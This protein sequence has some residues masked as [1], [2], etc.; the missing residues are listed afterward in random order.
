[1]LGWL[2]V[3]LV[4]V[5]LWAVYTALVYS[6]LALAP[7]P[8]PCLGFGNYYELRNAG[9][10]HSH[11]LFS[12]LHKQWGDIYTFWNLGK[13]TPLVCVCSPTIAKEVMMDKKNFSSR[14][15]IGWES[16]LPNS[17]LILPT[18][19]TWSFHRRLVSPC[20]ADKYFNCFA[21]PLVALL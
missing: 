14:G 13:T 16:F 7:G 20:F 6:D 15:P 9:V 1:M 19:S 11:K 2:V 4:P 18:N 10:A 3:I 8:P 5:L 21:A 17:L 12:R